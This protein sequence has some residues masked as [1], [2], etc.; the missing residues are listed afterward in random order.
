MRSTP[1]STP[2]RIIARPFPTCLPPRLLN[3]AA[4]GGLEPPPARRLRGAC[5]H[6]LC[7]TA[8]RWACALSCAFLAHGLPGSWTTLCLHAPLFD[9][10]GP[11]AS[12]HCDAG[13]V[14]FR[15]LNNVGSASFHFRGSITRPTGSLC[16]LRSR[17]RPR[18][19]QHS[20]PAGGQPC[21]GQ[22][23]HLLG[24]KEGF[25][26]SCWLTWLPPSPSFAW[27]NKLLKKETCEGSLH[28][29][30]RRGDKGPPVTRRPT[31]LAIL[32]VLVGA[33]ADAGG[34][35]GGPDSFQQIVSA[36]AVRSGGDIRA[37]LAC[38]AEVAQQHG[39]AKARRA[40]DEDPR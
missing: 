32:A 24:R 21:P 23:S 2:D 5:P 40:V 30:R 15:K 36:I 14:A 18:T 26:H 35:H 1:Q 37:S 10:G 34:D 27:R 9:P 19:T 39:T 17:G 16:T 13:D 25:R 11:P 3:A 22:D 12:G 8:A 33:V 38:T 6:L 7:S 28:S 20:V 29:D 31:L 4:V